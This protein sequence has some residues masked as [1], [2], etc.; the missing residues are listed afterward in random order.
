DLNSNTASNVILGA[1]VTSDNCAIASV[2]NNA[3]TV[4]PIGT[5]TVTWT[6]ID[7][8]GNRSTAS[9]QVTVSDQ[10]APIVHTQNITVYLNASGTATITAAQINNGSTDN[11]SIATYAL[12]ESSFSCAT[13]GEQMVVLTVTDI[14]GNAASANAMVTILDAIAPSV[15]A[16]ANQTNCANVSGSNYTIAP[17]TATDNCT[18]ASVTYTV[19]GAT[20]RT[21][22]GYD[23]SGAFSIGTSVI[24]W[25][26]TDA[27]GNATSSSTSV[28]VNPLP[29]ATITAPTA[30]ALCNQFV[31][32]ANTA[33]AYQWMLNNATTGS[34]PT[35]T[36]G[37]TNADGLYSLYI[38]DANGCKSATA[39]TYNYQKQ[40]L[41]NSYTILASK[42]VKLG[43]YNKVA[44]GSVG[45]TS[46]KGEAEFKKYSSVN[47][48]GSFVKSP[49]IKKDGTG[50]LIANSINGIASVTLPTMQLN[51]ANTQN[52]ASYT[53]SQNATQILSA[54]YK[55][56]TIKK[57]ANVTVTGNSFGKI[58]MEEGASIRFTA[59]TINIEEMNLDK[60][61]KNGRYSF[62]RFAPNSSIRVTDKVTIGSRVRVNEENYKVT[63]YLK[64]AQ[65]S[66]GHDDDDDDDHDNDGAEFSVKGSDTRVIANVIMPGGK[67]KVISNE[68]DDDKDRCSHSAHNAKDCRHKNHEHNDCNHTSH[69]AASCNDDVYMTGLFVAA[70]VESE[71]NTVVWNSYDCS[72]PA[73]ISTNNDVSALVT[74]EVKFTPV[75]EQAELNVLV[76]P[77]PSTTY[78]TLKLTSKNEAPVNIRVV[79]AV[80][81]L[82]DVKTK[83]AA[84][85]TFQIGHNYSSGTYFVELLQGNKRKVIQLIK[86]RG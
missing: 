2:S 56:L 22:V 33:A 74:D 26:V 82:V 53:V 78:F 1:P 57:G 65:Y 58:K 39:T 34:L 23:A 46:A 80:G 8:H 19:T 61:A 10:Q 59:S 63:F 45:I 20:N 64:Q 86:T 7:I 35:L 83:M 16:V 5:T 69:S 48:A 36:L 28:T 41:V 60:G 54:N 49:K 9:Q 44:T 50:V 79:D 31:L 68:S 76:M 25:T 51:N 37:L 11:T 21:G 15:T 71:G 75:V 30:D 47:G 32:T 24:K 4:Y 38:T 67:L 13:A 14:Y 73:S 12:N 52:L 55:T 70:E 6:V 17:L 29:V 18:I 72:A 85:S 43:K 40:N 42:E 62:V 66:K 81:R 3:P 84:N 77:N 27:S